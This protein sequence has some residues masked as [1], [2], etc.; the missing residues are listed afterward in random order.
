[1]R[2]ICMSG[3][4]VDAFCG[5]TA[6]RLCFSSLRTSK[7]WAHRTKA[8][9]SELFLRLASVCSDS[10]DWVCLRGVLRRRCFVRVLL[11]TAIEIEQHLRSNVSRPPSGSNPRLLRFFIQM[12]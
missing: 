12:D 7:G 10:G 5:P 2:L 3:S 4:L 1:M 8:A 9:F 11:C 6:S